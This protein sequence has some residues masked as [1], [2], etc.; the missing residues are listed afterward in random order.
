M[1]LSSLI[2]ILTGKD[3]LLKKKHFKSGKLRVWPR[4]K[5]R[6]VGRWRWKIKERKE[7][8]H[9]P[10]G[11][12]ERSEWPTGRETKK[13]KEVK[14]DGGNRS[15]SPWPGRWLNFLGVF[16]RFSVQFSGLLEPSMTT[17]PHHNTHHLILTKQRILAPMRWENPPMGPGGSRPRITICETISD[18]LYQ[19]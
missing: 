5:G 12:R 18:D 11:T 7:D 1:H 15:G 13:G 16:R 19:H 8:G 10:I 2:K 9:C 4:L 17:K 3:V 14:G 6:K